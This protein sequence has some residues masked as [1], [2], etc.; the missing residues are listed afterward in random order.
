MLVL[1]ASVAVKWYEVEEF[2]EKALSLLDADAPLL[3]PGIMEVEVAAAIMARSR[4]GEIP[5]DHAEKLVRSW[6]TG[7][8]DSTVIH[9]VENRQLLEDAARLAVSL[10]HKLIDC[11]YIALTRDSEAMLVTA[12][13]QMAKKASSI[14]GLT[15]RLLGQA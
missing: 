14:S 1:D 8:I 6:L 7:P 13:G 2:H 11:L 4:R 10:D 3:A 9:L 5:P 12:D 15:V